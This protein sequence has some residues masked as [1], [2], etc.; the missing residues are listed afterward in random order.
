MDELDLGLSIWV[1]VSFVVRAVNN[2]L[3]W[4]CDFTN[5]DSG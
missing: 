1:N 5:I 4:L 2:F 3:D